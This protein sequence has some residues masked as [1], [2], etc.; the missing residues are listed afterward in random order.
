M[1]ERIHRCIIGA[2][3]VAVVL[4]MLFQNNYGFLITS[5]WVKTQ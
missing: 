2:L 4:T 5:P 1:N 3:S